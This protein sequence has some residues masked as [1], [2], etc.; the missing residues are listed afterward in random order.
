VRW[1]LSLQRVF[2]Y[3]ASSRRR[4]ASIQTPQLASLALEGGQ[5]RMA[6][7]LVVVLPALLCHPCEIVQAEAARTLAYA[8]GAVPLLGI[9]FLP[10]L[11]YRLQ[12]AS[13]MDK[14]SLTGTGAW[15]SD[16]CLTGL[17]TYSLPPLLGRSLFVCHA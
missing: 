2:Q 17:P 4:G 8:A 3:Q 1:L 5:P 16:M 10:A 7:P 9:S 11:M 12:A 13:R 14:S 15:T 6:E